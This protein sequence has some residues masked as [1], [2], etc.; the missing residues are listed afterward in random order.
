VGLIGGFNRCQVSYTDRVGLIG[1]R[2]GLIGV[3]V[4]LIGVCHMSYTARTY[5]RPVANRDGPE[6]GGSSS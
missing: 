1:V 2:V 4:G 3:R 6:E 5:V